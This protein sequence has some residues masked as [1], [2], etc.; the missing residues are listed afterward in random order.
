MNVLRRGR[1]QLLS[2]FAGAIACSMTGAVIA[3]DAL[4]IDNAGRIGAGTS[5]PTQRL[6]VVSGS[7]AAVRVENTDATAGTDR[8]MFQ[9]HD[10]STSKVRFS[11]RNENGTWS[12]DTTGT[13][14]QVNRVGTGLT[15]FR[16][17]SNGDTYARGKSYAQ[18]HVNTSSRARKTDFAAVDPESILSKVAALP[19][20]SWRYKDTDE[21]E[22]HIGP[23][24]ED[25]QQAFGLSD[26]TRISTVDADGVALAAIKGLNQ[27]ILEM[28]T[29][30][31]RLREELAATQRAAA[32]LAPQ[33]QA[34]RLTKTTGSF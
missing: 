18:Q 5:T 34:A 13:N 25:F 20:T 33:P 22:R 3:E 10:P 24:A 21:A 27:Q 19:I 17:E 11:M 23:T 7:D 1:L 16:V 6:H 31:K 14:F 15:E 12:F 32:Q 26:G 9:L 30:I 4:Y 28:K 2:T 29:E 8:F